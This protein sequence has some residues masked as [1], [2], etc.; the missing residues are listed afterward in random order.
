MDVALC[1]F[2]N[3]SLTGIPPGLDE[4]YAEYLIG[5]SALLSWVKCLSNFY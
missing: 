3:V 4:R 5:S 1:S 2:L